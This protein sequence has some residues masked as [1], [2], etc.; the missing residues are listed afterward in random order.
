MSMRFLL[1]NISVIKFVSVYIYI[2]EYVVFFICKNV[3]V[4][5]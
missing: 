4:Y 3:C 5:D 2:Y 1:C